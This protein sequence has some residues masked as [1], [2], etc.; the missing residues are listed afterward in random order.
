MECPSLP[1]ASRGRELPSLNH[2]L[3]SLLPQYTH[4]PLVTSSSLTPIQ[5]EIGRI[6]WSSLEGHRGGFALRALANPKSQDSLPEKGPTAA[7][8]AGTLEPRENLGLGGEGKRTGAQE[9]AAAQP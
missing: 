8:A 6:R 3:S 5:E 7:V 4:T 9:A 1:L 2:P